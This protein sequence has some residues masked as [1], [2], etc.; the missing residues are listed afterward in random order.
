VTSPKILAI[1]TALAGAQKTAYGK[2]R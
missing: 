1:L 2:E